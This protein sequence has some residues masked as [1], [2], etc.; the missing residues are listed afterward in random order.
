MNVSVNPHWAK[1]K[2][3][4][5]ATLGPDIFAEFLRFAAHSTRNI[6]PEGMAE[7]FEFAAKQIEMEGRRAQT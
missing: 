5:V 3:H 6:G 2:A 7:H 4:G 1:L